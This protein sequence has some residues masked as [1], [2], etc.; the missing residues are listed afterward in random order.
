MMSSHTFFLNEKMA[1]SSFVSAF[2]ANT[3]NSI[4]KS[5]IFF[6]PC[7]KDLI[8]HLVSTTFVLSLNVVLISLTKSFQSWVLS[9]LCSLLSFLYAYMPAIPLLRQVKIAMILLLV[10]MTL[11][12]LRNSLIPLYQS[13]NFIWSPSNHLGSST[14][15]LGITAYIF[16]LFIACAS[17]SNIFVSVHLFEFLMIC[18][19]PSLFDNVSI[20]F[21][22]LELVLVSFHSFHYTCFV[23][24]R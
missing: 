18:R 23:L 15:L 21:I 3:S 17:T 4:M 16:S 14:M 10:F 12:L 24:D 22:L 11:L 20:S 7:L 13:S 1:C 5:T 19:D 6:F 8:F 9:S 2:M